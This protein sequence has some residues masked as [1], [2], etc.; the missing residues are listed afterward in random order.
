MREWIAK[1]LYYLGR[2]Y[3]TYHVPWRRLHPNRREARV[4]RVKP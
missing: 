4:R 2:E 1:T 3:R